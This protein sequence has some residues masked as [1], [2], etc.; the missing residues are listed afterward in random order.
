MRR[1]LYRR[2]SP[3]LVIACLALG[4]VLGGTSYATVAQI[5]RGSVGT[6]QLKNRAVTT[7]KLANNSVTSAKI[8]NGTLVQADFARGQLRAGPAG[9][10]GP[11]GPAGPPGL[12]GLER[13]ETT[14]P[15]N[16]TTSKTTF[17]ACPEGKRL[18]GGGARL[19]NSTLPVGIIASFPDNDNIWRAT[20][21]EMAA[22]AASWSLTVYTVC[23]NAS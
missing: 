14:G 16:S 12:S 4:I 1:A 11:A 7:P 23:A 9:H 18:V 5:P 19:S 17:L 2:P 3:A 20:A 13:N 8:R 10:A 15:S 22:T 21:R 6:P